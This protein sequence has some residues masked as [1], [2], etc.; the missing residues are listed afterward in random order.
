MSKRSTAVVVILGLR[1][2]C[3][4]PASARCRLPRRRE[5]HRRR[6]P[7]RQAARAQAGLNSTSGDRRPPTMWCE[8]G[9]ADPGRD[10]FH[11]A[12]APVVARALAGVHTAI[13]D[14]LGRLRRHCCRDP[15]GL[16]AAPPGRRADH[17]PTSPRRSLRRLP[18]LLA[19][20]PSRSAEVTAFM[21]DAV[22][23]P[24]DVSTGPTTPRHRQPDRQAVVDFRH[25]DAPT[26]SPTSPAHPGC[27]ISTG[28]AT[29]RSTPVDQST[30]PPG[31]SRCA[32]RPRRPGPAAAAGRCSGSPPPS[33][34]G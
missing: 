32:C 3:P 15:A 26:S 13:Y 16:L 34:V 10:P 20:F 31:G 29:P 27:A 25:R 1:W 17:P 9:R 2:P 6:C 33:G 4:W 23:D 12:G 19:L 14:G 22:Y 24:A 5:K 11:Q 28:P 30:T 7:S 18:A 8:V 21:S